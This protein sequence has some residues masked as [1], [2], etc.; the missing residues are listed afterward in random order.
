MYFNW[1]KT[2]MLQ[3][4]TI[5]SSDFEDIIQQPSTRRTIYRTCYRILNFNNYMEVVSV[6]SFGSSR[7]IYKCG[8]IG[9]K[10]M[11]ATSSCP[12]A[13]RFVWMVL[14]CCIA[15]EL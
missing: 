2:I 9:E 14:A 4:L 11:G 8:P 3:T 15:Y 7:L 13:F 10:H 12:H 6:L 5:I 1:H